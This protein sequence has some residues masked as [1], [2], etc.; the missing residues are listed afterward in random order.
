MGLL[1]A[2]M[3]FG[4]I[5]VVGA[6]FMLVGIVAFFKLADYL[7]ARIRQEAYHWIAGPQVVPPNRML[8]AISP[9]YAIGSS[10]LPSTVVLASFLGLS[11]AVTREWNHWVIEKGARGFEF[12]PAPPKPP[13]PVAPPKPASTAVAEAPVI[14]TSGSQ[15]NPDEHQAKTRPNWMENG[16]STSGDVRKVVLSSQLWST[17]DEAKLDLQRQTAELIRT[18]FQQHHRG[19]LDPRG[20]SFLQTNQIATL[21]VKER[22]I[23]QID[24]DFGKF[25]APMFRAWWQAEISPQVRTDLYPEWKAA[26]S[27]NRMIVVGAGL[28]LLTLLA[29]AVDCFTNLKRTA[30]PGL[31][32]RVVVCAVTALAWF[33][34]EL[35]VAFR[36][37]A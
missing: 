28:A 29:G 13:V 14:F 21:V 23:E 26:A 35:I 8:P 5:V 22:F 10:L 16:D 31:T 19:L 25:T 15:V 33:A 7:A 1:M 36:L 11:G 34:L 37:M 4:M 18:D 9:L 32:A 24:H 27:Q 6:G 20:D 3:I 2:L 12:S 17:E 30:T